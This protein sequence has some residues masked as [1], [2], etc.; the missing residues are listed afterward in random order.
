MTLFNQEKQK[1][2][3]L[4]RIFGN[5]PSECNSKTISVGALHNHII[6]VEDFRLKAQTTSHE[7][8]PFNEVWVH[9]VI[10]MNGMKENKSVKTQKLQA[11]STVSRTQQNRHVFSFLDFWN[12]KF[13][14]THN[15]LT[16]SL[17]NSAEQE[18]LTS[19]DNSRC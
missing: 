14:P 12:L 5:R 9:Q 11:L 2:G 8:K 4:I 3:D 15:I 16:L 19:K 7:G 18:I 1:H 10:Q 17:K 6:H 13:D